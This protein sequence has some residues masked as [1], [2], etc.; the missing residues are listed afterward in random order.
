MPQKIAFNSHNDSDASHECVRSDYIHP[1]SN[2]NGV[3]MLLG[4]S[5]VWAILNRSTFFIR[6]ATYILQQQEKSNCEKK[7]KNPEGGIENGNFSCLL[8]T[9]LC[10]CVCYSSYKR[11]LKIGRKL[12]IILI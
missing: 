9:L 5:I 11:L 1:G 3:I 8:A 7:L 4:T 12:L 6:S 2:L 10:V